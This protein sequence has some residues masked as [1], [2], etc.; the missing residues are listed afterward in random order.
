[1]PYYTSNEMKNELD[2]YKPFQQYLYC[3]GFMLTTNGN[4]GTEEY[5]FY[6]N[7]SKSLITGNYYLYLHKDNHYYCEEIDGVVHF[8]VG[9]AYDPY[10][11]IAN[12][13]EILKHL[14]NA[15]SNNINEYWKEE[16]NL[17][18]VFC[19]GY[20][21]NG[22]L[23]YAVDCCGMQIVYYA[24][25]DGNL[26]L[27][28]H[29]KLVADLVGLE[30]DPYIKRLV[31]RRLYRYWGR[32]LPGD[33]SPFREI[34][35]T[36]PNVYM[37]YHPQKKKLAYKRFYPVAAVREVSTEREYNKLIHD[38]GDVIHTSLELISKKWPDKKIAI[39]VTGGQDSKTTLSCANGLYDKFMYF[40]YVSNIPESVDAEAA[41]NICKA[42]GIP[43]TLVNIPDESE[44][45]SNLELFRKILMCNHGCIRLNN[46]NDA[47][48]RL[49][50]CLHPQ[51][52]IEV[53]S[54]VNE[55]GRGWYYNKYQ[56]KSF[57]E[58]PTASYWRAMHKVYV[59]PRILRETTKVF[60][61]YLKRYYSDDVFSKMSWLDLYFWEFSWSGFEALALTSEHKVSYDI[62][63][64][65]NNRRYVE[66]MLRLPLKKRIADDMPRDIVREQNP[67]ITNT[68]ISIKDIEHTDNRARL[69]RTYLEIF[70]RI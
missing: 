64:P 51:F 26:Y 28:S 69:V 11:K 19:I 63:I 59:E 10:N 31:N 41:Q 49:Y 45:Y 1:M 20:I 48:K 21:K 32:W 14:G 34:R 16:S 58:R 23:T 39:S 3:R 44:E 46:L 66:T 25:L 6:G 13:N 15:L 33:L 54:W 2:Q 12:E 35:R 68:G 8:L 47:K 29:S 62:T 70:S 56:K 43:H 52:D 53:K 61:R 40:S 18:G 7:W 37:K 30:Q 22:I 4:I 57:P 9:H 55:M 27:S 17:T 38:L 5:P 24:V 36:Q 50:F 65:Y 60:E 42:V 67:I